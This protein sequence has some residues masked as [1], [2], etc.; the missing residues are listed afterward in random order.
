MNARVEML[1]GVV[2]DMPFAEYHAVQALSAS[3]L[4]KLRRSPAHYFGTTLDPNRPAEDSSDAMVAGSLLHC[5][6]LE[7]DQL[8]ARYVVKPEDMSFATKEGRAWKADHVG[9]QIVTTPQWRTSMAQAKALRALPEVRALLGQGRSEVSS[10]WHDSETGVLCKCRLDWEF[11][12]AGGVIV[13]DLKTCQD[14]SPDGFAKA[15]A[16]YGYHLQDAHYTDGYANASGKP[17]LGFVFAAVEAD[18]PHA[19]AAY[20]LSDADRDNA[21]AENRRLTQLYA[22][23]LGRGQWPGYASEI[24]TLTL[25]SWA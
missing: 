16:R 11:E 24:Q 17:V 10:F 18:W 20:M 13:L 5:A 2:A 19:A 7:P 3:G 12:T 1:R 22:D 21:R 9:R 14:A 6:V 25:P 15:V 23:C 8:E 4:K